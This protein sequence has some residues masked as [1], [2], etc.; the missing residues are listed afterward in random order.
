MSPF[1]S[2]DFAVYPGWD[3]SRGSAPAFN[4][5]PAYP[6]VTMKFNSKLSFSPYVEI[7]LLDATLANSSVGAVLSYAIF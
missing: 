1:W 2:I 7:P 6:G 4:D 3:Y 5:L